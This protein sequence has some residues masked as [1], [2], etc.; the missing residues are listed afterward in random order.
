MLT[1]P[2]RPMRFNLDRPLDSGRIV[3]KARPWPVFRLLH[4]ASFDGVPMHVPQFL[5]APLFG[6]CIEIVIARLPKRPLPAAQRDR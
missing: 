2:F 3:P 4:Q 1:P 6:P 5:D